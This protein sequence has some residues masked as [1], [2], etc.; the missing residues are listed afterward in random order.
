ML[1]MQLARSKAHLTNQGIQFSTN[2]A[3][4]LDRVVSTEQSVFCISGGIPCPIIC[5]PSFQV[6]VA[7]KK[8]IPQPARPKC[9]PFVLLQNPAHVVKCGRSISSRGFSSRRRQTLHLVCGI[10]R[11]FIGSSL[12]GGQP[13]LCCGNYVGCI[14]CFYFNSR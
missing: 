6:V 13:K 1:V 14:Y 9:P 10:F 12:S 4:L 3:L 8:E 2:N 7:P 11:D 5:L